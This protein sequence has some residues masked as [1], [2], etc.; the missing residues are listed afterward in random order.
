VV[1]MGHQSALGSKSRLSEIQKYLESGC[2]PC[3]S[4]ETQSRI[5]GLI[6]PFLPLRV[7]VKCP[8]I[9]KMDGRGGGDRTK[10]SI[11]GA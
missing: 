4:K 8:L 1:A 5:I 6:C 10:N 9:R 3:R 11:D 2:H 7:S